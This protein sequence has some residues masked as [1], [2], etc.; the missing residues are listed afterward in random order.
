[1]EILIQQS[2]GLILLRSLAK[3]APGFDTALLDTGTVNLAIF[4]PHKIFDIIS[5]RST[6]L[7][8]QFVLPC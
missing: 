2:R 1:M 7:L 6:T 5:G 4:L 3:L 8:V